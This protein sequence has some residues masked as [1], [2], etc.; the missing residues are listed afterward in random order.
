MRSSI[1][2]S[3]TSSITRL[4]TSPS[5]RLSRY[6]IARERT[7]HV[8]VLQGVPHRGDVARRVNQAEQVE[9]PV[10]RPRLLLGQRPR[11]QAALVQA[12]G[13]EQVVVQRQ[14]VERARRFRVDVTRHDLRIDRELGMCH[15]GSDPAPSSP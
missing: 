10:Q 2:I 3:S 11:Q 6:S 5:S 1:G 12:A 14:R 13:D 7:A 9:R 8:A 4:R 15:A